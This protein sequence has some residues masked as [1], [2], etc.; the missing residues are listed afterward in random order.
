MPKVLLEVSDAWIDRLQQVIPAAIDTL[1]S[2]EHQTRR[3]IVENTPEA[4]DLLEQ[5][6]PQI[7]DLRRTLEAV[8]IIF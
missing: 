1:Y 4:V 5:L 3:S 6:L 2:F 7:I 8:R